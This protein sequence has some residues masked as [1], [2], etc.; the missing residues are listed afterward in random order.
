MTDVPLLRVAVADG[1]VL[2]I[3][4]SAGALALVVDALTGLA[5]VAEEVR[6]GPIHVHQHIEYLGDDALASTSQTGIRGGLNAQT[7]S[8]ERK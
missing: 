8:A 3:S 6:S 2:V 5:D 1:P 7:A 4:G